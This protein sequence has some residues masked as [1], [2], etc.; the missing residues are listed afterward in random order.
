MKLVVVMLIMI[1][2]FGCVEKED[3]KTQSVIDEEKVFEIALVMKTLTNPFF[4]TME[5]GARKASVDLGVKLIT[6]VGSQE[7]AIVQQIS[8]VSNLIN[9]KVD[10]IV[11]APASSIALIPVLKK[12][13]DSGIIIVNIDNKLDNQSCVKAGLKNV[14]YIS[15]DNFNGAYLANKTITK[16]IFEPTR[17]VILEGI[18][19]AQNSIERVEGA[20]KAFDENSNIELIDSQSANWKIDQAYD[21]INK[22]FVK[23]KDINYIFCANDMMAI[24]VIQ[25]LKDNEIYNVTVSG[26]DYIL[27][28]EPYLLDGSLSV[29]VDQQA[30]LQGY[31]GVTTA[32]KLLNGKELNQL[33]VIVGCRTIVKSDVE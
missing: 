28:V 29:T 10:A 32:N 21:V 7:T 9:Q 15:V 13:Q 1:F 30:G 26:F 31:M 24:G 18:K 4:K 27:E 11:I 3:I 12:A 5:Q 23:H 19:E 20:K 14:P 17:A 22:M 33:D 8:I 6:K 2:L 16:S 25:Y